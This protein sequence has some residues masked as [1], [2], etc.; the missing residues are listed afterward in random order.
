MATLQLKNGN[1]SVNDYGIVSGNIMDTVENFFVLPQSFYSDHS[2][3]VLSICNKNIPNVL[4]SNTGTWFPLEKR[5]KWSA[6]NLSK[7]NQNL[8]EVPTDMCKIIKDKIS[9]NDIDGASK[10]LFDLI[11]SALPPADQNIVNP[12]KIDFPKKF[13]HKRKKKKAKSWFDKE[14]Q[15]VK[16]NLNKLSNLK[17]KFPH[18]EEIRSDHKEALKGFRRTCKS[19]KSS[20][21]KETFDGMSTA[22]N[23]T[24]NF[25]KEFRKF[26]D[27]RLPKSTITDKISANDWKSYFESLHTENRDQNIPHLVERA[28]NEELN[29]LFNFEELKRVIKKMKNKKAEG[30][31]KMD[32]VQNSG[33][34]GL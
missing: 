15:I 17:S 9:N 26:S 21:L 22:L 23:D 31:D 19:K 16:K 11:D 3:I 33:Q 28:P 32:H 5:K 20:F 34:P 10:S 4:L 1:V 12:S 24:E 29:R 27:K 2:E 13:L 7:L 14:L 8:K 6:E 18:N 30:V 25:W